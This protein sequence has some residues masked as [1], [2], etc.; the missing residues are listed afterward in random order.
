[1]VIHFSYDKPRNE[2]INEIH[3]FLKN[4]GFSVLEFAPKDGFIF[5]DYKL[6]DWGEG[7]RLISISVSIHDKMTITGKGRMD[8]P[9]S[10]LGETE[11]LLKIK[12]FDKL[13]YNIQKR[14]FL[15]LITPLDSLGYKKLD[16]WP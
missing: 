6:Y 14:T 5:T 4:E 2:A 12:T 16:H 8:I 10:S 7:Q 3:Q 13:P 15:S 9:M 11:D 1:M